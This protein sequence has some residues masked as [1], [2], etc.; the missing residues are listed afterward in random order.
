MNKEIQ[1]FSNPKKDLLL[2]VVAVLIGFVLSQFIAGLYILIYNFFSDSPL[3]I[4]GISS[5]ILNSNMRIHFLVIQSF[6]S[7]IV[8]LWHLTSI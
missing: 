4:E 6:T 2:I 3:K 1:I 8:F 7:L 5:I